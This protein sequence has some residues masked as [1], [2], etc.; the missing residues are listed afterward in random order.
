MNLWVAQ[1]PAPPSRHCITEV[2]RT[3]GL[4]ADF[5]KNATFA[6]PLLL[7]T[8]GDSPLHYFRNLSWNHECSSYSG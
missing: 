8:R 6:T 5:C 7:K 3:T 1:S 2:A 4:R